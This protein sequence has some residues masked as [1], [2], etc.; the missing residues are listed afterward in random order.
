MALLHDATPAGALN[1]CDLLNEALDATR[2]ILRLALREEKR[3]AR[4][5][6]CCT[7]I[8]DLVELRA[9]VWRG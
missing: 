7:I 3:H 1:C 8:A 4:A 9:N 6:E 2:D 5:L